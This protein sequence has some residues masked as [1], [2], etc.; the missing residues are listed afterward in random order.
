M[1][2]ILFIVVGVVL[3]LAVACSSEPDASDFT[4]DCTTDADCVGVPTGDPCECDCSRGAINRRD[5]AAYREERGTCNSGCAPQCGPC[6]ALAATC[7]SGRCAPTTAPPERP[8]D[9]G[10]TDAA[11]E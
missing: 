3:A 5:E 1:R 4:Q 8:A 7:S 10:A 11:P 9:A 2:H 6:P